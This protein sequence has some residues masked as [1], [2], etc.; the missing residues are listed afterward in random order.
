M[1]V[2]LAI[3][4]GLNEGVWPARPDPDPW[5]S[6]KMRR[7][8]GLLSPEREIGLSAHDYQQAIAAPR[9]II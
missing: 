3:L 2:D 6:R 5:L 8:A 4:G 1:G 7:Q 9:V